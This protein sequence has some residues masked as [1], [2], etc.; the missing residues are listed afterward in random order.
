MSRGRSDLKAK[1]AGA[2]A[3]LAVAALTGLAGISGMPDWFDSAE[4]PLVIAVISGGL[5]ITIGS[6][7]GNSQGGS[8][9]DELRAAVMSL[10]AHVRSEHLALSNHVNRNGNA[11]RL[12]ESMA[13]IELKLENG[14]KVRDDRIRG[15][16]DRLVRRTAERLYGAWWF[17]MVALPDKAR[18]AQHLKA[19][20]HEGSRAEVDRIWRQLDRRFDQ[21]LEAADSVRQGPLTRTLIR[22]RLRGKILIDDVSDRVLLAV[23]NRRQ[24][25][26]E[27]AVSFL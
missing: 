4:D 19:K 15:V 10:D 2:S 3:G 24:R 22:A 16:S 7:I 8:A 9:M 17:I 18:L 13:A 21:F 23:G 25:R 20:G 1:I 27:R 11:D 12:D 5:A 26:R 14:R 6:L